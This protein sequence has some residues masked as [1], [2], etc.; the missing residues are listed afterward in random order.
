[1]P[2]LPRPVIDA[3]RDGR[4]ALFVGSGFS[5]GVPGNFPTWGQLPHRLLDACE[6]YD[7]L[8]P[9]LIANKRQGFGIR[10]SLEQMLSELGALQTALGRDYQNAL[11]DIFRPADA[12]PGEA[13]RAVA[14]L[15]VRAIITTNYD[16]LFELSHETPHRQVYTW[17]EADRTL[18]DLQRGHPMRRV[19][20]KIHGSVERHE[21][22]VMSDRDYDAARTDGSYQAVLGYLLQTHVFLFVGYGMNDPLDLDLAFRG[23]ASAFK[24]AAQRHY[25]LLRNPSD[26]DRER[27][28]R[29]YNARVIPYAEHAEVPEILR[30]LA[31]GSVAP[32]PALAAPLAVAAPTA[33]AA[34]TRAPVAPT[35][36][37]LR[38]LLYAVLR[39]DA[40][41]DA[42]C[43]DYFERA[44]QRFSGGMDR[45]QKTN[46]LFQYEEPSAIL[47]RLQDACA[48]AVERHTGLLSYEAALPPAPG[49]TP[50]TNSLRTLLDAVLRSDSDLDAFCL[51]YFERTYTR[52][53]WAMD[54]LQKKALLFMNEEPRTI[55]ARLREHDA[56]AVARHEGLLKYE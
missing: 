37:S 33:V 22:V 27:L 9:E 25:V 44:Y 26:G 8:A 23:N 54:R 1:M 49:R 6:R 38:K 39:S 55:L 42:F 30:R 52:F 11:N 50:T 41:W 36:G 35:K 2:P 16:Q 51:D 28:E 34:L 40:D 5:L 19:L 21:T 14:A 20:F 24:S 45:H 7:S 3:Y 43:I 47:E 12:A 15:G 29:E 4:L 10:M 31:G 13:H 18:G 46:I 32:T 56:E 53:S 17:K 48:E